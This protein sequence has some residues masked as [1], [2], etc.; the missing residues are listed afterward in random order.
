MGQKLEDALSNESMIRA[1]S[2]SREDCCGHAEADSVRDKL[3]KWVK[4]VDPQVIAPAG[5]SRKVQFWRTTDSSDG[6]TST[7]DH[8]RIVIVVASGLGASLMDR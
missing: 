4:E 1:L 3:K 6:G 7:T 2:E 5:Y 8:L